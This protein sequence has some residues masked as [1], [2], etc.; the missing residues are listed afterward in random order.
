MTRGPRLI[1]A[2]LCA[3]GLA[4]AVLQTVVVPLLPDFPRLLSASP[5][6]TGWVL[7]A[8]LLAGSV[9]NPICGRLG[10]LFG[11]RRMLL[12]LLASATIGCFIS[13][14]AT[15][16]PVMLVGRVLQGVAM[17]VVPMGIA[18]MRDLLPAGRL[19]S[20]I[21]TMS[22]TLGLG[23]AIALPIAAFMVSAW[24]WQSV[25]W[26]SGSIAALCLLGVWLWLPGT[27]RER[28]RGRMDI[29][30]SIG[31]ATTLICL[32]SVISFGGTWGWTSPTAIGLA[33]AGV[34]IGA[35]WVVHQWRVPHPLVDLRLM[36]SRGVALSN[37]SGVMLG[38]AVNAMPLM[39]P[40]M[41]TAPILVGYGLGWDVAMVGWILMPGGLAMMASGPASA[42]IS[43]RIGLQR[44]L[45]L[46][47]LLTAA[48][49]AL[50]LPLLVG[51]DPWLGGI[52]LLVSS[53]VADFGY[54][55][56]YA[57]L[58]G[59]VMS[60]VPHHQTGAAN[61]MNALMRSVGMTVSTAVIAA[62][63]GARVMTVDGQPWATLP[64]M[65]GALV[66][67]VV[68]ATGAMVAALFI[69]DSRSSTTAADS[70]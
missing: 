26:M 48:G 37:A 36:S 67:T 6:A 52:L 54:G 46:G 25:F 45:V 7:T 2:V 66:L 68:V 5:A 19:Q 20:A 69:G 3:S 13:G 47:G 33:V 34:V 4:V 39:F 49:Y 11:R 31:L 43:S 65:A 28:G 14:L 17:G 58:S 51:L 10:D 23:S 44:T 24:P 62:V 64:A 30:G 29:P 41:I 50:A 27:Q 70:S 8:T 21:G 55:L 53:V 40:M 42:A 12:I 63:L 9:S 22:A 1:T 35:G 57:T 32:L 60:F 15:N 18:V 16:L 56:G 61:G 59:L 38:F